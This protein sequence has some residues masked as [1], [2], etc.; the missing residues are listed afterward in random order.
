MS[1]G[2]WGRFDYYD[3]PP[4]RAVEGGVVVARPGKVSEPMAAELVAAAEME[5]APQILARG[6]TYARAGQVVALQVEPGGF[7]AQIQGTKATP[8]EVRL[9]RTTI[10]GS[11]RVAADCTCPYGCDDGWCKHAA[12][13]A[14]VAAFLLDRDPAARTTWAGVT[15]PSGS[16][17][18]APGIPGTIADTAVVQ[19]SALTLSP[20]DLATLRSPIPR[21]DPQELLA[22][23]EALVPHPNDALDWRQAGNAVET[24]G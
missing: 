20:D 19:G 15:E 7:S 3:A 17:A 8:Y 10:S 5:S 11:D 24:G 6:R 21:R 12:A 13:L 2:R 9:D 4:R 22:A 23:A 16:D 1:R 14:Y 18:S